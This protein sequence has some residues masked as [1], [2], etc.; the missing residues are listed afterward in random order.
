[1]AE[2]REDHKRRVRQI[3]DGVEFD[4][5]RVLTV[6]D[7][8]I[9]ALDD[10]KLPRVTP[11]LQLGDNVS[12]NDRQ[13][14]ASE[15]AERLFATGRTDDGTPLTVDSPDDEPSAR[16]VLRL[17]RSWLCLLTI[18]Q[19]SGLGRQFTSIYLRADRRALVE[20]ATPEGQH[21]FT[22]MKRAPALDVATE[23]LTPFKNS[24]DEDGSGRTYA[25]ES[26]QR[27]T[28]E[29]LRAAKIAGSVVSRRQSRDM[30]RRAEDRLALYNFDDRSEI[31][32]PETPSRIRIAPISRST[33][34]GRLEELTRP[35]DIESDQPS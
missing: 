32:F 4:A 34:R 2:S 21:H 25:I 20:V 24:T 22:A 3:F 23:V 10:P 31:M 7:A 14:A 28:Q 11:L 33:L 17:R 6:T 30:Q 26:W 5:K 19:M 15:A 8:E 1:M 27:D 16:T 35:I 29:L 9:L 18:D 13:Q 12:E